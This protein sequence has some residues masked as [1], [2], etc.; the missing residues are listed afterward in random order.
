[1]ENFNFYKNWKRHQFT[2]NVRPSNKAIKLWL[3]SLGI[4]NNNN[5]DDGAEPSVLIPA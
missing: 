1:M 3:E 4:I 5:D 2:E